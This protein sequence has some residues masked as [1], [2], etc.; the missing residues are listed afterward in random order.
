MRSSTLEKLERFVDAWPDSTSLN[1]AHEKSETGIKD[2]RSQHRFRRKA[3]SHFNIKL[4]PHNPERS[5]DTAISCPSNLDL[6]SARKY[7]KFVVTS[8]TNNSEIVQDFFDTLKLFKNHHEAQLAVIPVS[9]RNPSIISTNEDY[10]W[11]SQTHD[12]ILKDRLNIGTNL[13]INGG[14]RI[15]A[16]AINPLSGMEEL[17]AGRNAVYGHPQ[18]AL[19]PIPTPKSEM[20]RFMGTTGSINK[21]TYIACKAGGKAEFHHSLAAT[22]IHVVGDFHYPIQLCWDGGGFQYMGEYWTTDGMTEAPP[23]LALVSGD[24]HA[25]WEDVALTKIKVAIMDYLDVDTHAVH[26]LHNQTIGSHHATIR[27]RIEMAMAG[28]ICVESE[29][30]LSVDYIQKTARKNNVIIG[31]NHN[32][33]ADQWLSNF[34]EKEDPY[35]AQF[36]AWLKA[37]MY[38]TDMSALETF[39]YYSD[40]DFNYEFVSRDKPLKIGVTDISQHGD[41]G[42][43]GSRGSTVAFSKMCSKII[44]GHTHTPRIIKG[45]MSVGYSFDASKADYAKG[46]STWAQADAVIFDSGKSV[47]ILYGP[48]SGKNNP[49]LKILR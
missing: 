20:T 29:M 33:H 49:H 48:N 30:Q 23:S 19:S 5:S 7:K 14:T 13:V 34:K 16:T 32:D 1:D 10:E 39:F 47:L 31:S 40:T 42:V 25:D 2:Q 27:E 37:N 22:F 11:D 45:A 41:K 38:G 44:H 35:N 26:D 46:I 8:H 43:N 18:V 36:A 6:S 3:E 12:Y 24:I 9:Y 21:G 4:D 28:K 15:T 17:S